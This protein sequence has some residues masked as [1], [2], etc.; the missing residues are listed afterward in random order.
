MPLGARLA[1]R[2]TAPDGA[3]TSP[4]AL[5][6][7]RNGAVKTAKARCR[8]GDPTA[9]ATGNVTCP[10]TSAGRPAGTSSRAVVFVTANFGMHGPTSRNGLSP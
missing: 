2:R 8:F 1:G 9:L 10:V 6:V 7:R 3:R 4:S 5:D